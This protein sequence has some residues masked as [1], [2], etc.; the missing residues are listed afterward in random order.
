MR[1]NR[2]E[3]EFCYES[4]IMDCPI[5]VSYWYYYWA[6]VMY[7]SDMSGSPSEEEW[8]LTFFA[9]QDGEPVTVT[10]ELYDEAEKY[11]ELHEIPNI[12]VYD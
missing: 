9:R 8:E 1:G 6:G 3:S 12:D 5:V 7:Y 2:I 10:D 11:F 4:E